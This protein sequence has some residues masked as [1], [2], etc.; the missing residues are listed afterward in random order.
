M[1]AQLSRA[2]K[3]LGKLSHSEGSEVHVKVDRSACR[4]YGNCVVNAE[5]YLDLDDDD[6][7]VPLQ[8]S[9]KTED[10]SRVSAAVDSCP[11]AALKVVP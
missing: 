11:V 7:A 10:S 2:E 9:I 4:G 3:T 6:I 1:V 5:D 8:D